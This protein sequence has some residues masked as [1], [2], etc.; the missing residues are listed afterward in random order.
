MVNMYNRYYMSFSKA[1][2]ALE[3][4]AEDD[5]WIDSACFDTQ[6]ALEFLIKHI[7]NIKN[8]NYNKVH[9]ISYLTDLLLDTGFDFPR[10]DELLLLA[11]TI[12][13][14]EEGSRCG[15]GIKTSVKTINRVLNIIK[16]LDDEFLKNA[17]KNNN[18][19]EVK[20]LEF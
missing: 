3:R 7:L 15:S 13:S 12:T 9:S 6:Q 8:V 2:F 10:S 16:S 11:D 17:S 18:L 20:E 5:F 4:I 14:W 19:P 1:K